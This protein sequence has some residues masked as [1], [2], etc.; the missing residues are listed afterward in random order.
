M[1]N[2]QLKEAISEMDY[3]GVETDL[4]VD[5]LIN[6]FIE[7]WCGTSVG[8]LSDTDENDGQRLRVQLS[9]LLDLPNR[10]PSNDTFRDFIGFVLAGTQPDKGD[11]FGIVEEW[12]DRYKEF[13]GNATE[14][15]LSRRNTS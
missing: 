14:Y 7:K 6:D 12:V 3:F 15:I 13:D 10:I 4:L 11:Q 8:H 9:Y 2:E 5:T 1:T